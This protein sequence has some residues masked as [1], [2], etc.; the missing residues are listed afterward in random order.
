VQQVLVKDGKKTAALPA[1]N[2]SGSGGV[3]VSAM[4]KGDVKNSAQ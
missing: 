2:F 3:L 1:S 4:G